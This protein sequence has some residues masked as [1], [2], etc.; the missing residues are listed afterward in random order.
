MRDKSS[1]PVLSLLA[2]AVPAGVLLAA[3]PAAA[4]PAAP[5]ATT[6][7]T[8][9]AATVTG[10]ARQWVNVR[11]APAVTAPAVGNLT[12]GQRV[13]IL[14]RTTGAT[15]WDRIGDGRYVMDPYITAVSGKPAVCAGAA[16]VPPPPAG[17]T[18]EQTAFLTTIAGPAMQSVVE[19]RVPASVTVAQAI[20]ES[21]W[22]RSSLSANDRNFF[23]MKCHNGAAGPYAAGCKSYS[24]QECN[25]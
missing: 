2:L 16:P 20:L 18:A 7:A 5:T 25:S 22:G 24:T 1:L 21:G 10:T 6:V 8:A 11:S 12:T 14:C 13:T 4:A 9:V 17:L 23:G 3:A 19:N 15:A